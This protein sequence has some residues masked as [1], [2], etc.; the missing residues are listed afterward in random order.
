MDKISVIIPV[1]KTEK[2]LNKCIESITGQTYKNLEIIL[3]DDD[4]PDNCPQ[5]CD[6]WAEKDGRIKVL[7]IENKGVANARNKALEIASGSYVAFADSDDFAE[8][9]M[10]ETLYRLAKKENC[11]IAVCGFYGGEYEAARALPAVSRAEDAL[12]LIAQGDFSFGV[13]WNK[14][15]KAEVIKGVKM[16]SLVCC[17]DL[18]FN[19][20][21]FKNARSVCTT[22]EKKYHYIRHKSSTTVQHFNAGAFDAV[23]S[24]EII[25]NDSEGNAWEKYAVKGLITSC[26]V[27][28]SDA[29]KADGFEKE[30]EELMQKILSRKS[31]IFKSGLYSKKDKIKTMVLWFS[32]KLFKKITA[33]NI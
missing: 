4:S 7:H 17:E 5:M 3:V 18:V 30:C 20:F 23:T 26:F 28:L 2:Y 29:I 1:Y 33:G 27:V 24:K 21:A 25:L 15:Y 14:L 19:Y 16:P 6:E 10:L 9:D 11:D 12:K 22:N 32:K 13:L 8:N 31:L